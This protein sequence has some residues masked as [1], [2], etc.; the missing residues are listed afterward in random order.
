M[1][2]VMMGLVLSL[3]LAAP[4][5]AND[6]IGGLVYGQSEA[7]HVH[8]TSMR[9]RQF[10]GI[11]QQQTDFSCGA[12]ALATLFQDG[13]AA[14][15]GETDV[16]KGMMHVADPALV[17]ERGFSLLDIKNYAHVVGLGAEG[18]Q[19]PLTSLTDLRVP[20]IVLLDFHGY[21]HFAILKKFDGRFAYL[22]D[23]ALGNRREDARS[24]ADEWNG[25]VLVVLGKGYVADNVL[26]HV[27]PP[28][29]A[30]ALL[31][32]APT[33]ETPQAYNAMLL[34]GVYPSSQRL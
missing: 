33:G 9:E 19:M 23:P 5:I 6:S 4:A 22:A 31:S 24:F 10:Q 3:V 30:S 13:Y 1:K 32:S 12:A 11:V 25:I 2:Q 28:L 14:P 26:T 21:H 29:S 8:V 17:R 34:L 18:Y 20:A 7:A 27:S 15:V 16:L